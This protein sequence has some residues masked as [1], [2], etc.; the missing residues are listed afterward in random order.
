M[1]ARKFERRLRWKCGYALPLV[2]VLAMLF[3]GQVEAAPVQWNSGTGAND[4]WYELITGPAASWQAAK[5][6]AEG[7][8]HL[9]LPGHLVTITTAEENAFL[10][11]SGFVTFGPYIGLNDI[12]SEGVFEWVTGEAYGGYTNWFGGEP[13]NQGNE[14]AVQIGTGGGWNDIPTSADLGYIVE[15]ESA[16]VPE[17][18]TLLLLGTGL[19]GL[20]GYGR[21]KRR[22]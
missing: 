16:A 14:D 11:T 4:H 10:V 12:A 18:S 19:V 9:G 15:Y 22:A 21:R 17:P 5:T 2:A 7:L 1:K 3:A 20:V 6:A 13:N 8:S